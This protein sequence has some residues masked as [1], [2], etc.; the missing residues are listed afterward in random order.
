MKK[1]IKILIVDDNDLMRNIIKRILE[2]EGYKTFAEAS[3]GSSAFNVLKSQK[4]DLI[5]SDWNML[6]MT[7]IELLKKVREDDSIGKTP[8]IM[9]S[10]EG[11]A[12]SID[13][14]IK[15]GASA[16]MTKPFTKKSLIQ[17]LEKVMR[18]A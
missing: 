5:F 17:T 18:T 7:G 10:V 3:D 8:F 2:C 4:V 11:G 1:N 9:L 13:K 14:A 15:Y 16:F 12:V 6:G